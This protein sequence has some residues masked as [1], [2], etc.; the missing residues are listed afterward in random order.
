MKASITLN[1]KTVEI[2]LTAEQLE[3][4]G[5]VEE[6]DLI[7]RRGKYYYF[8]DGYSEVHQGDDVDANLDKNLFKHGN[9]YSCEEVANMS[10]DNLANRIKT[11]ILEE[12]YK[13]GWVADWKNGEQWKYCIEFNS[14]K[15][16]YY[17]DCYCI[18]KTIGVTY[19]T[20][21][22]AKKLVELLNKGYR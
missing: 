22:T 15:N 5:L 12:N 7:E 17:A 6:K 4:L 20:K 18:T 16:L 21:E 11:F 8:D 2:E 14:R 19:T 3:E 10:I 9:Y 13:S 1:N